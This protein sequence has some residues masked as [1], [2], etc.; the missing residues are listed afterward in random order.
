MADLQ[1]KIA[2][3]SVV[4]LL[5]LIEQVNVE[6]MQYKIVLG[7]VVDLLSLTVLV[8]V[9]VMQSLMFVVNVMALKQ[10]QMNA[11]KKDTA[12]HYLMLIRQMEH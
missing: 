10:I 3:V 5:S 1:L 11:S 8:N 4:V 7:I 2:Q 6:V 9:A 12:Y